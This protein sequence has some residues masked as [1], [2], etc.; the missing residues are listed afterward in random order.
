MSVTNQKSFKYLDHYFIYFDTCDN[1]YDIYIC[2]KCNCKVDISGNDCNRLYYSE[3][4]FKLILF[5]LTCT[6]YIIKSIID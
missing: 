5:T 6:E 1:F 2:E 4:K 3:E